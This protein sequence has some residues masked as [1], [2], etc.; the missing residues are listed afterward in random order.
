[1]EKYTIIVIISV[2]LARV[3]MKIHTFAPCLKSILSDILY[4]TDFISDINTIIIT[5][6]L[7]YC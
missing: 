1:M 5:Y 2:I 3:S 6:T 4:K 7:K